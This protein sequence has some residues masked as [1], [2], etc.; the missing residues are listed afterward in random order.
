VIAVPV[1]PLR[2][3]TKIEKQ[4][5]DFVSVYIPEYFSGVGQFYRNFTQVT[6]TEVIRLMES[7][8]SGFKN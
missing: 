4:V 2:A 7:A 5:E 1:A 6:D 3:V 8:H